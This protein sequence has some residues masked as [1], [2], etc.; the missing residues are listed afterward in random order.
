M[1]AVGLR[2][3]KAGERCVWKNGKYEEQKACANEEVVEIGMSVFEL[4]VE[5][6]GNGGGVRAEGWKRLAVAGTNFVNCAASLAGGGLYGLS[7]TSYSGQQPSSV[8]VGCCVVGCDSGSPGRGIFLSLAG[9]EEGMKDFDFV[10]LSLCGFKKTT[11]TVLKEGDGSMTLQHSNISKIATC[12][13]GS[14][15]LHEGQKSRFLVIKGGRK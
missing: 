15:L 8:M 14:A 2:E 10:S 7:G 11:N 13:D 3:A 9:S 6:V 5:S 1:K 4:A 12:S